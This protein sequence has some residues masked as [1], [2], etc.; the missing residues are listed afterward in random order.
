MSNEV[1]SSEERET[2]VEYAKSALSTIAVLVVP[3]LTALG[4]IRLKVLTVLR[5][6]MR[7][8]LGL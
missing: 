6:A 5:T 2:L 7:F 3:V 8:S 4:I 1:M